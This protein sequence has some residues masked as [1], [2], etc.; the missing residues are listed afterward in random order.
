MNCIFLFQ[1]EW[2]IVHKIILVAPRNYTKY[3]I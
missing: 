2:Y 1:N 3:D